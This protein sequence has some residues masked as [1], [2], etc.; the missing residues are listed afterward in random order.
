[1]FTKIKP[2][3]SA[4]AREATVAVLFVWYFTHFR[5]IWFKVRPQAKEKDRF[6]VHIPEGAPCSHLNGS[7]TCSQC[8][9]NAY[10][11]DEIKGK[12]W[13][14]D[15]RKASTELVML[16]FCPPYREG[17][18]LINAFILWW[19]ISLLMP[20]VSPE[21]TVFPSRGHKESPNEN[22][23]VCWAFSS[24]RL[25]IQLNSGGKVMFAEYR[26]KKV[27]EYISFSFQLSSFRLFKMFGSSR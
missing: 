18:H 6:L 13:T 24:H 23:N 7:D 17:S 10:G 15:S 8:L 2:V 9:P 27:R 22:N 25:L 12:S 11:R 16:V 3:L 5:D 1:M 20:V 21:I 19:N 4:S 14:C 26:H